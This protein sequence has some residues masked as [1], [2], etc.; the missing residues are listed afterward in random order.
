MTVKRS[1][2]A[3]LACSLLVALLSACSG[4]GEKADAPAAGSVHEAL[5]VTGPHSAGLPARA[6][7]SA[8]NRVYRVHAAQVLEAIRAEAKLPDL[9]LKRLTTV[10]QTA[11]HAQSLID[12]IEDPI[13]RER[14]RND[15]GLA[16]DR[17]LGNHLNSEQAT[18][19]HRHILASNNP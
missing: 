16:V 4:T 2:T 10:A 19:V 1:T 18:I 12:T 6:G 17:S 15:L 13:A 9:E 8:K 3:F 11:A 5:P 7:L 14:A